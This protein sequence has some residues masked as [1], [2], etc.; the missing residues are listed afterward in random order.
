MIY[1]GANEFDQERARARLESLIVKGKRF[2]IIQKNEKISIPFNGYLHLCLSWFALEVG[3]KVDYIKQEVFK[4][5]INPEIFETER[6]NPRTGEIRT[7]WKSIKDVTPEELSLSL[8]RFKIYA[9]QEAGIV[10]PDAEKRSFLN[11]IENE[12]SKNKQWL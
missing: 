5:Q 7:E 2:E 3:E 6:V 8:E 10:I 9:A 1:N 4:K 12:I 11:H